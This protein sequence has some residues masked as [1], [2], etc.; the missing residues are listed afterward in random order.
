MTFLRS[1]ADDLPLQEWLFQKVFP[2]EARLTEDDAYELSRL[3]VMEYLTSGITANFDMYFMPAV[4]CMAADLGMSGDWQKWPER[5]S[6]SSG[7]KQ[8]SI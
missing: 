8:N 1:Y 6:M 7:R 5:S 4:V 3:A 2:M